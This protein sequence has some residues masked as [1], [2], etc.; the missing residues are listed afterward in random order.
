M[1]KDE[2]RCKVW[3]QIRQHDLRALADRLTPDLFHKAAVRTNVKLGGGPLNLVSLVWLGVA[4]AVHSARDF[5]DVLL[6]TMK[7]LSDTE[8]FAVTPLGREKRNAGRRKKFTQRS[9]HDPRRNDPTVVSEA[10]FCKARRKMPLDFWMALILLLVERFQCQHAAA[11]RF[12]DFRLL[13]MDG[14]CIRLPEWKQL[15][16]HYG[17]AK[18]GKTKGNGE[19][20]RK[21][22]RKGKKD[23]GT[24]QARM[25]MLQFPRV[26][27]P[28]A[29]EVSPLSVGEK[30][31]A[32]RLA[33]HL[34]PND[35]VLLDRG[36][37][38]YGFFSQIQSRQAYFGIRLVRG[39]K[40]K[41]VRRL[42]TK[43]RLVRWQPT[44]HRRKWKEHPSS[45]QL[46]VIDYQ[47]KGFR[48]SAVVTNVTDPQ[49]ISRAD[50]VRLA[51]E[52]EPGRNLQPGLYHQRWEIETT[53][54]ELKVT[55]GMKTTLRGR[56]PEAIEYE[57]AGH[58][59]FYLLV[60]WMM[61][62]AAEAHGEDPLR[63][64]FCDALKEIL[65]IHQTLITAS[66]RR[67]KQVLLPRL[68][69]RIGSHVVPHRPGRHYPRPNDTTVKNKG[70]GKL[71]QPAK[72]VT[73]QG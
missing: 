49:R 30:T 16:D 66:L 60:R 69:A 51:T 65:D 50:W 63:L 36:F 5:G 44:D 17:T 59:T 8:G 70:N 52:C 38:S 73:T 3:E 14:T 2:R 6:L 53:F 62:E 19:T 43:D 27:L 4:S 12:G 58:V 31:L 67:V 33:K 72:L 13:A 68:Y 46:R 25:V 47:I 35:L 54:K 39:V 21:R 7:L 45:I 48:P 10:A 20:K 28:Y 24:T 42:G 22:K 56:T 34:Q 71:Q 57:I 64:S 18:N 37:W 15:K 29:Y 32:G 9:K 26:R 41:T 55:Q 40:L 11:V 1:F 23:G 61:V